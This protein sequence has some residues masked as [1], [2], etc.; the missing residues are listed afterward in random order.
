MN[1]QEILKTSHEDVKNPSCSG[2]V[3]KLP[4]NAEP[5]GE[6]CFENIKST[7]KGNVTISR[8]IIFSIIF[9]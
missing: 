3:N 8:E 5:N 1:V 6:L 7:L 4:C 2:K 9:I